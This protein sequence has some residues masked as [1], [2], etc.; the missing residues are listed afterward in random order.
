[1]VVTPTAQRTLKSLRRDIKLLLRKSRKAA[2]SKAVEAASH[3]NLTQAWKAVRGL[4]PGADADLGDQCNYKGNL[5]DGEEAVNG[6]LTKKMSDVHTYRPNSGWFDQDFHDEVVAA[7]PSLLA[8][9]HQIPA[10]RSFEM[11]DLE[12]IC[13]KLRG[14]ETKSAGPDGVKYWMIT[15]AGP[16]F[17]RTLLWYYNLLWDWEVIPKEWKHSHVRY[18]FKNNGDKFDLS[19]YRPISLISCI[20][21]AYT[22]MW[23]PRMED[24][25]RPHL[26]DSQ[27]GFLRNSSAAEALWTVHTIV[28]THCSSARGN[29]A[30][31]CFA[32]TST[33]FDT[34]WR[35]G[36]YFTLYS[37]GV[38]G[39][40]LR[41]IKA[42]HEGAT[43][44]GQWYS[45]VS[46]RIQFSQ[47]VR[48]GCVIAP[49]L[50]VTFVNPLVG[51]IP[52][53]RNHPCPDLLRRAFSGALDP[54][55]GLKVQ[56][57]AIE[58][59]LQATLYVDDV[60]LLAP[61]KE[62][63]QRNLDRYEAFAK[64]WR[65]KLNPSKFHVVPYGKGKVGEECL[66][67]HDEHDG[68]IE[69]ITESEA[70]HLGAIVHKSRTASSHLKHV[71]RKSDRQQPLVSRV[72]HSTS[73]HV[74][75]VVAGAK[76]AAGATYGLESLPLTAEILEPMTGKL[77]KEVTIPLARRAH[78]APKAARGET[79]LYERP[80]LWASSVTRLKQASMLLKIKDDPHPIRQALLEHVTTSKGPR[81]PAKTAD[82]VALV[83]S[84]LKRVRIS[85]HKRSGTPGTR[86]GPLKKSKRKR[87]LKELSESLLKDQ[88]KALTNA[89]PLEPR[90]DGEGRG[91]S[92]I[93]NKTVAPVGDPRS[94]FESDRLSQIQCPSH[95]A[96]VRRLRSGQVDC[97]VQRRRRGSTESLSCSCSTTVQDAEHLVLECPHTQSNRTAILDAIRV[98]AEKDSGLRQYLT[99]ADGPSILLATLGA[100]LPTAPLH[101]DSRAQKSLMAFAGPLW[102][103]KFEDI[104]L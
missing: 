15:R 65:Y 87:L 74:A 37:Y 75:S 1:M 96:R 39:K 95:R 78:L 54:E 86:G 60:C 68:E 100:R 9:E 3:G 32:D 62:S 67:A 56:L 99:G 24:I 25:L 28:D 57:H 35:D 85:L 103:R 36:L 88:H 81:A 33:A 76:V 23:L 26:A 44:V 40:L 102:A 51:G 12:E 5:Y 46:R 18:L 79:H 91:S 94:Y 4:A 97:A 104:L 11:N 64:K 10:N 77:D 27:A 16:N 61:D 14:R 45:A 50:Y 30:Y 8:E 73:E 13:K 53:H 55:D 84:Q 6:A 49:L 42:W 101:F 83:E 71:K 89:I 80:T 98:Q 92:S 52:E 58:V 82:A 34:V 38:K 66:L 29:H 22:M 63:L 7:V 20:G 93:F 72:A 59:A 47:G 21:K 41:M 90:A 31:A 48:Q 70:M 43:A 69:I 2:T 19:K 17:L